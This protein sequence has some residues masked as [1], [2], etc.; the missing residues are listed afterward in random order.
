[1]ARYDQLSLLL[2]WLRAT[3]HLC[4]PLGRLR[5]VEGVRSA[6][7]YLLDMIQEVDDEKLAKLLKPIRS[8]LDDILGNFQEIMYQVSHPAVEF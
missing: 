2:Q 4:S 8:H 1:M 7:I 6:L 5:T 3:L